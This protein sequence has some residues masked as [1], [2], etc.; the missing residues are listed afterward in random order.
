MTFYVLGVFMAH[1]INMFVLVFMGAR[2]QGAGENQ[3]ANDGD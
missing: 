1:F 3:Q 2:Q